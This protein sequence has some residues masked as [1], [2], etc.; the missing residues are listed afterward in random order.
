[1]DCTEFRKLHQRLNKSLMPK[2]FWETDEYEEYKIHGDEC[3]ACYDWYMTEEAK[4]KGA[5][6]KDHPCPHMAYYATVPK[7]YE[8]DPQDD[9]DIPVLYYKEA[10]CYGIPIRDGGSSF[11]GIKHCPWCGK[12]LK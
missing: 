8:G 11:L 3:E 9:P 10:K 4:K 2:E 5:K 7:D 1:M 12:A 6:M